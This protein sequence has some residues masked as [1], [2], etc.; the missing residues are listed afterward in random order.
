MYVK[1]TTKKK[2]IKKI[3]YTNKNCANVRNTEIFSEKL[4]TVYCGY[5]Y[6]CKYKFRK[7]KYV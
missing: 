2:S 6:I 3:T 1:P 7:N 4:T 5:Q